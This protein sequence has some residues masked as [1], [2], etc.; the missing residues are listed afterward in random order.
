MSTGNPTFPAPQQK[1]K[2]QEN[3]EEQIRDLKKVIAETEARM[4]KIENKLGRGILRTD[5]DSN[6]YGGL[7]RNLTGWKNMLERLQQQH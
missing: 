4:E 6:E 2:V 3:K 1:E 7:K 5:P